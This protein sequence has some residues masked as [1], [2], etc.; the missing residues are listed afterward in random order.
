LNNNP[1]ARSGLASITDLDTPEWKA[2]FD[3]LENLQNEFLSHRPHNE[4]YIWPKDALHNWSRVWEYPYVDHHLL[5]FRNSELGRGQKVAVDF[6]SG[7]TFFPFAV[8]RHGID[9]VCVD[10]NPMYGDDI[11]RV[12][13]RLTRDLAKVTFRPSAGNLLPFDN[14]SVDIVY[15]ISVLEH[16]NEHA[17]IVSEFAR[18]L[19]SGGLLVLTVDVALQ[20]ENPS[21]IDSEAYETLLRTLDQYFVFEYARTPIHPARV[22]TSEHSPY[23]TPPL[24]GV[25]AALWVAKQELIKPLL[26]RKPARLWQLA[27]EGLILRKK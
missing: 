9:V 2:S 23:G 8:S 3:E 12:A 10:Q 4:D 22:L 17:A 6:G 18:I 5:A 16:M 24:R 25:S 15:S 27:C 14:R 26:G 20:N 21:G 1:F 19:V 11:C 7:V 13:P